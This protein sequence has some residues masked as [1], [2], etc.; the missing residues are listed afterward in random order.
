LGALADVAAAGRPAVVIPQDRPHDEQRATAR[1]LADAGVAVS[2]GHWPDDHEWPDL[3]ARALSV[4]GSG[5]TRWRT[6]SAAENAARVIDGVA[7]DQHCR[8]SAPCA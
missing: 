1:A 6:D 7:G 3:F 2:S 5:W 4:G 8:R